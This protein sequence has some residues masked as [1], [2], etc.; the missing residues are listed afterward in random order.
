MSMTTDFQD[1][2][3]ADFGRYGGLFV[4][5]A[6]HSAGANS[7]GDGRGGAGR[8]QHR[9]ASLRSGRTT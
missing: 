1:W 8:D 6:W 7:I 5:M 2:W 9:F 4:R 3:P